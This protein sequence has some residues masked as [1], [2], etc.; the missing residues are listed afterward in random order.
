[1]AI[2]GRLAVAWHRHH[3]GDSYGVCRSCKRPSVRSYAY[4]VYAHDGDC[5][6][7]PLPQPSCPPGHRRGGRGGELEV[8]R[9][10]LV[11]AK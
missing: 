4:T 11:G 6:H 1:M 7:E 2:H 10:Q 5:H 9:A 3:M 8:R